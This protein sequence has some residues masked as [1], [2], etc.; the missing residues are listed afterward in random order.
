MTVC[1]V[2]VVYV[3][4]VDVQNPFVL[5]SQKEKKVLMTK[6]LD[7]DACKSRL[8]RARQLEQQQGV[9]IFAN[10]GFYA[11]SVRVPLKG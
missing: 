11:N 3:L 2:Y 1:T 5:F 6:R 4:Y 10:S 9:S 8:R 7:L